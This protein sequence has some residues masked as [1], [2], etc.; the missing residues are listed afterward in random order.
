M[1][2]TT[3]TLERETR[4][5]VLSYQKAKNLQSVSDTIKLLLHNEE[6]RRGIKILPDGQG[7]FK[8]PK[9]RKKNKS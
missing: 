8:L 5:R 2:N 4:D 3:V 1:P 7:I 9:V 6:H